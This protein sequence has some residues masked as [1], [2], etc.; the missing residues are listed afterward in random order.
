MCVSPGQG[1]TVYFA[2]DQA[3]KGTLG[4]NLLKYRTSRFLGVPRVWEKIEEGVKEA[5]KDT[6]GIKKAILDWAKRQ[7]MEHHTL[8]MNGCQASW[9]SVLCSYI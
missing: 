8:N 7:A 6:A 2:D 4:K 1:V 9:I 5:G 3:L